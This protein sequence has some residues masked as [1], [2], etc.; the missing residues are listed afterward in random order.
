MRYSC[1]G[2]EKAWLQDGLRV[3]L[4]CG[5]ATSRKGKL[6]VGATLRPNRLSSGFHAASRRC[7]CPSSAT[8]ENHPVQLPQ[9]EQSGQRQGSSAPSETIPAIPE[10]LRIVGGKTHESQRAE[11]LA[12]RR[13]AGR[14]RSMTRPKGASRRHVL[15]PSDDE[16]LR[17]RIQI[18]V[19][20]R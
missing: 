11:L 17:F 6:Q 8:P 15:C 20:K 9:S 12:V 1:T 14:S 5:S 18:F 10:M 19:A 13:P 16:S 4:R 2:C 7:G 3:P